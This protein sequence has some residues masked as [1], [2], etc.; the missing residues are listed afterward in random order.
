MRQRIV[1]IA[2]WGMPSGVMQPLAD[3]LSDSYAASVVSLPGFHEQ[4]LSVDA[5]SWPAMVNALARLLAGEPAYLAGW[6]MGGQL[7]TLFA[8][9]YPRQVKGLLTLASNPCFVRCG[10]WQH[11][12]PETVFAGF[13]HGMSASCSQALEQFAILCSRGGAHQRKTVKFIRKVLADAKPDAESLL[14]LLT[15]LRETDTRPQ[16][17][18]LTGPVIHW[19]ARHDALVPFLLA[20]ALSERYPAQTIKIIEGGHGFWLEQ[21]DII[22]SNIDELVQESA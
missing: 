9:M 22:V 1:L 20:R 18:D 17:A 2:G 6:S 13:E 4:G 12:M 19:V 10:D 16:L 11:A 5:I 15:L 14:S 7:A 8:A 3:S 21:P